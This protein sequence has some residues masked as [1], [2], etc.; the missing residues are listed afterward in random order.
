MLRNFYIARMSTSLVIMYKYKL[1]E[2]SLVISKVST[3]YASSASLSSRGARKKAISFGWC[4][5]GMM[6]TQRRC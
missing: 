3:P 1:K 6:L 2:L 5:P 4:G